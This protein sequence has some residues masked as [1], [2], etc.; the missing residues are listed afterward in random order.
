MSEKSD[1]N[2][3]TYNGYI[4]SALHV[5]IHQVSLNTKLKLLWGH[6]SISLTSFS[7]KRAYIQG[8]GQSNGHVCPSL[9]L[10]AKHTP[11][12]HITESS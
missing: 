6:K 3:F 1:F 4:I 10:K 5:C 9:P 11:R 7:D 8:Y 2:F 12:A